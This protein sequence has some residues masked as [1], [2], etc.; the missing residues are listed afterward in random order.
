M[1]TITLKDKIKQENKA[2]QQLQD[3]G[4]HIVGNLGIKYLDFYGQWLS[5]KSWV[6]ALN[7]INSIK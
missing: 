6:E 5:F 3:L 4:F 1:Q 7:F 2:Y